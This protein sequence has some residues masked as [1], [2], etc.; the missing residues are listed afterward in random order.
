MPATEKIEAILR[1]TG[2]KN[3]IRWANLMQK[4]RTKFKYGQLLLIVR[5]GQLVRVENQTEYDDLSSGL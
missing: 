1:D 2:E 4:A 3:N 5:D